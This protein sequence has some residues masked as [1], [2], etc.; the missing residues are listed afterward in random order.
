MLEFINQ[1]YGT[2]AAAFSEFSAEQLIFTLR[3]LKEKKE[4]KEK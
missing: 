3:K 4:K 2:N 1:K